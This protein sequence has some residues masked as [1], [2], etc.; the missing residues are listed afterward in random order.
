MP[1][2]LKVEPEVFHYMY[3]KLD[4][5]PNNFHN[6]FPKIKDCGI[7]VP[8]STVIRVP[9]NVMKAFSMEN[10]EK[11]QDI[12]EKWVK[13]TVMPAFYKHQN[14]FGV[15]MKNGTFSNKFNANNCILP[16][17]STYGSIAKN[18]LDINYMS[19]MC[20]VGG[21]T[22]IV[23]RN[24]IPFDSYKVATIYNGLPFRPEFRIFYD[25]DNHELCYSV[26]YWD[27]DYC[28][29]RISR[30]ATERIVYEACYPRIKEI[31]DSKYE[32]AEQIVA[33]LMKNIT[34]LEGIWS[35]DLLLDEKNTFWLIDMAIGYQSAYYDQNKILNKEQNLKNK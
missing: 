15:F 16:L 31:F 33:K 21:N 9:E 14:R 29:S 7:S 5:N 13:R 18:I 23:L 30:R 4:Q 28:Y 17:S 2:R 11:S 6:W 12:V 1:N 24:M 20:G 22:E 25:F 8:N 26:N 27:W 3:Q 34:G 35:I 32:E 19:L 10:T